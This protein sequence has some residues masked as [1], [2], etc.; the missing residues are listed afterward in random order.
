[1]CYNLNI[2]KW[3]NIGTVFWATVIAKGH[4]TGI[5]LDPE[6]KPEFCKV[7]A[8]AKATQQPFPKESETRATKYRECI[9]W[10][11]WGPASV[12][13]LSG[14]LY[15]AVCIDDA[16][17]ETML[18]FQAKKSQTINS[19]KHDDALI[20]TQTGNCI[21]V[22]CSDQG[23]EFLSDDLTWHQDMRGTKHEFTVH[24]SPQKNGVAKRVWAPLLALGLPR[25]LWEN[26][27]KH[28]T[29]LQNH[30]P[31]H[32]IDGKT[33]YEMQHKK[34]PHLAGIQEFG[35]AAYVKDLKAGKLDAHAKV[36]QFVGYDLESKGYWIYW[37][38]K[39]S[40][41]VECNVVFNESNVTANDNIHIT[42][43]DVVDEGERDKVLQPPA[44][45]ANAANAP[46]GAPAPQPKVPDIAP[47]PTL[48][49]EPQNSVPFPSEQEPA[50]EPLT[51]PLQ[52]EDPQP[53]LGQGWCVQKKP[54]GAYKR[55]AQGLPPLDANIADLQNNIPE[56]EEGWEVELPPDF[57]LIGALGTEPK[58][59][60]NAISGPHTK[61]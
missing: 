52:E 3:P 39:W 18:Y 47:E 29:W 57:V 16:T 30:T 19:Y 48:E 55:M 8:K 21:K 49:P 56:D 4:I 13:S 46:N 24:D 14:N 58:S 41:S 61:E 15:V 20:E 6:S 38:Q 45:N 50:E 17:H 2:T 9:H 34:K 33:L 1:M 42:A 25:F 11:L 53:E 40:I 32:A 36:G 54:P 51:E 28:A 12:R 23:G 60:D 59:L 35:V 31:A 10:D 5:Q 26:V 7:C 22:A 43:G 44:S 37:P 27:M